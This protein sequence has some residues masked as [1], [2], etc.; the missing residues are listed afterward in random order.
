MANITTSGYYNEEVSDTLHKDALEDTPC[1]IALIINHFVNRNK[2]ENNL[3]A[4]E[5]VSLA[6]WRAQ[7][8]RA[9][10]NL[11]DALEELVNDFEEKLHTG[12]FHLDK[13]G[14]CDACGA[15]K[16][17]CTKRC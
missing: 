8:N 9:A 6:E 5:N 12:E 3:S 13:C 11:E 14:E 10:H 17:D 7:V 16:L 4:L 15:H 1:A 2:F